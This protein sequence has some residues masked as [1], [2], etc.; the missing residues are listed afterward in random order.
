MNPILRNIIA[1]V[2]GWFIGSAVN[3]T[4]IMLGHSVMPIEGLD[5]ND[6]E[7]FAAVMPTLEGKY[8]IFP[9][10]GH[11]LGTQ[12]GAMIAGFISRNHKMKMALIV[13]GFF[14]LGGITINYMLSGPVWFTI[15]DIVLAYIPMAWIGG[16]IAVS[17]SKKKTVV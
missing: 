11:A 9:F 17:Y 13:G 12:I 6:M 8:F 4:L 3:M 14:L 10:L 16:N 1:V 15:L 2:V 5:P 7:A